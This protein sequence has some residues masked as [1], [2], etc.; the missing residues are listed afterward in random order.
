[1]VPNPKTWG[2]GESG[3]K[4]VVEAYVRHLPTFGWQVVNDP[5][6]LLDIVAVHAGM[7]APVCHVAHCHGLYWTA[8]YNAEAWEWHANKHV[9]EMCQAARLITVPSEWV[10]EVFR[11]ELRVNPVVI[12]HGLDMDL[13]PEPISPEDYILWNKNRTGDVCDPAPVG[14]LAR[15]FPQHRFVTTFAPPGDFHNL[16]AIGVQAHADMR[17][18]VRRSLVYLATTKETFGIGILEAMAAGVPILGYAHGGI[19]DLV[20]HGVNGYLAAVGNK[21]DLEAGLAYCVAHRATLGANGRK[22]ALAWSWPRQVE[23]VAAV[24]DR[25]ARVPLPTAA[26]VIPAY[27]YSSKIRKAIESALAQDYPLLR[28][29]VVVDDGSADEG[30]TAEIARQYTADKDRPVS[31]PTIDVRYVRQDNSGVAVARNR[32]IEEA[33]QAGIKYVACLDADDWLD[34]AFLS[35]CI[36]ALEDDPTLG[37]A[38]TGLQFHKPDGSQGLSTWPGEWDFDQQVVRRNQIP[39]ACVFRVA[40]WRRLGGYRQRYAPMGAGSEDAE[41]WLRSGAYGWGA[42]KASSRGLFHYAWQSGSVSGNPEYR[43]VDWLAWHPWAG[44]DGDERHPVFSHAKPRAPSHPVT[45][46]D[47]PLVSVVIPVGPGHARYLWDALD[48]LEAQT[49]RRWEAVVVMDTTDEIP[50]AILDCYPYVRWLRTSGGKGP[51]LARNLGAQS[52]RGAF[53]LFL[54]ADDYLLP[55]CLE[56]LLEAWRLDGA[57]PYSDYMGKAEISDVSML[58]KDLQ[59]RVYYRNPRTSETLIGYRASDFDCKRAVLQPE[60]PYPFIWCNVTTLVPKPWHEAIG[61]FD[62][63]MKSWE[64]V[65][66]HWR[67][68]RSGRC[69]VRVEQELMV[70]RFNTGNRRQAGLQQH[71]AIVEYVQRKWSK[72]GDPM[73]C[74]CRGNGKS[75]VSAAPQEDRV[76]PMVLAI[77]KR[78]NGSEAM[79]DAEYVLAK[80]I[81]PNIGQHPVIGAETHIRYGFRGGGEIFLVHKKDLTAQP[82]LFSV[83]DTAPTPIEPSPVLA[84]PAPTVLADPVAAPPAASAPKARK[85]KAKAAAAAKG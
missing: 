45:Q 39:T 41:F 4:R 60:M 12:G 6:D 65:E 79:S 2:K 18:I 83:I 35:T 40:M 76:R 31:R 33:W 85:G 46:H 9:V 67:M 54:D 68:A 30:A 27:N 1:M 49:F 73:G 81:H 21:Q 50:A 14:D 23:K 43:E 3:I 11:R 75:T 63:K 48:S 19:K 71:Q 32:G 58:A 42:K 44:K 17:D 72:A 26:I 66:Y 37:I 80:Y 47:E 13:W 56:M 24:Y 78:G 34:P 84:P 38:Y 51:G 36:R 61:G 25:A 74:G 77:P 15:A 20:V 59:E 29:I 22:M 62:E 57:I 52:A 53:L 28:L 5:N 8:D 69:Y 16:R 55:R 82:H 70:Y 10:A 64:D 7:E